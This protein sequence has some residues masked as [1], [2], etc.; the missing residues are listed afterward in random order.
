MVGGILKLA[1]GNENP[2]WNRIRDKKE[3]GK[4]RKRTVGREDCNDFISHPEL[5]IPQRLKSSGLGLSFNPNFGL[6]LNPIKSQ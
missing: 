1:W 6:L 4:K 3:R 5:I 2:S